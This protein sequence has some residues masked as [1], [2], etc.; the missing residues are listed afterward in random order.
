MSKDLGADTTE[1]DSG[2]THLDIH[3]KRTREC[4][5]REAHSRTPARDGEHLSSAEGETPRQGKDAEVRAVPSGSQPAGTDGPPGM[6]QNERWAA[7]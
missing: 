6:V 7:R 5:V 4:W 1:C 2:F 3:C